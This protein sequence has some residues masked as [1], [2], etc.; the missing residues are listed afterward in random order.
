MIAAISADWTNCEIT[1]AH[2]PNPVSA[3]PTPTNPP[4]TLPRMV[5]IAKMRRS[6]VRRNKAEWTLTSA[7]GMHKS[8]SQR[9]TGSSSGSWNSTTANPAITCSPATPSVPA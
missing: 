1:S 6:R 9:I 7:R 3:S 2:T 5:R 8:D 4:A